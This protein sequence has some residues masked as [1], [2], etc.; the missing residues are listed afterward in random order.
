MGGELVEE[1][2]KYSLALVEDV[3][4]LILC[5]PLNWSDHDGFLSSDKSAMMFMTFTYPDTLHP[6]HTL[7]C[8][9]PSAQ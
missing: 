8:K 1:F 4:W 9:F 5:F 3:D 7:Y 2:G 6:R